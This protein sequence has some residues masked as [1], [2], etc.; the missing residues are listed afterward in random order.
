L[1]GRTPDD[2]ELH[3]LLATLGNW[4]LRAFG[5]E[6]LSIYL[7]DKVRGFCLVFDDST[8]VRHPVASGKPAQTPI[9][10]GAFFYAEGVDGY[11]AY[12]GAMPYGIGWSDT[13]KSL[14][15]K[16]GPPKFEIK[17]KQTGQ[18]RSHR[19]PAGQWMLTALYGGGGTSIKHMH[20]GI[21]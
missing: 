12:A 7:H 10:V 8:T 20:L 21:I 18:L 4:P 17:N 19:W 5:P 14:V 2:S 1:L 3:E 9:F 6:E 15:S 16:I 11:H 13:A